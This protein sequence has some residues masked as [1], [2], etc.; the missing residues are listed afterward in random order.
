MVGRGS[1]STS[2]SRLGNLAH[3]SKDA[4][5]PKRSIVYH[6]GSTPTRR[7]STIIRRAAL[8]CATYSEGSW[9][10]ARTHY[11]DA[12]SQPRRGSHD[13]VLAHCLVVS[14]CDID[15]HG[16]RFQAL[17]WSPAEMRT[18]HQ[19]EATRRHRRGKPSTSSASAI[20][21]NPPEWWRMTS[22]R[23]ASCTISVAN[24][25]RRDPERD[26]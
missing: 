10:H 21:A 26:R 19:S 17:S 12:S 11:A 25:M 4:A 5:E 1:S 22:T 14:R 6:G 15:G 20:S 16:P 8:P 3:R 13:D 9:E 7:V 2:G 23:S 18:R 24:A